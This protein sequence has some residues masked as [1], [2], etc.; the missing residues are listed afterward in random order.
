MSEPT[1]DSAAE[2]GPP[3]DMERVEIVLLRRPASRPEIS[4]EETER[5]QQ[6][7]LAHL[8]KMAADGHMYV[9]GPF[10]EQR[11]EAM[12]GMAVYRTGSIERALELAESDPAV[13]AGRFEVE[14]MALWCRRGAFSD[15]L[16]VP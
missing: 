10:D 9:A 1:A 16:V 12:R 5:L 3:F 11:D 2:V 6:L 15:P 7:H 14:V 4:D 13:I 8:T